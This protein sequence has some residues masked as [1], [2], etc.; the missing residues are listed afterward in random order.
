MNLLEWFNQ[1]DA[2][3]IEEF[4]RQGQEEHLY[5]DFKTVSNANLNSA[6]DKKNLAKALSGFANP[7]GGLIVWGVDARKNA[8]GIDCATGLN[9]I[10]PIQLFVSRLNTLTGE[11]VSPLVDGIIHKSII[12]GGEKGCAVTLV[13]ESQSGPHMAKP[14]E[15]RYYKRSGYSFYRMEHFDLEDM[16][17]RRQKPMLAIQMANHRRCPEEDLNEELDFYLINTG[18]AIAKYTGVIAT[19]DASVSIVN[20]T[21]QLRNISTLNND[22]QTLQYS[23]NLS[24]VRQNGNR[25]HIG[26]VKFRRVHQETAF[27]LHL[28]VYCE[29]MKAQ[30]NQ[31]SCVPL[32]MPNPIV[33]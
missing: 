26:S 31:Y 17:G 7:S 23:S 15:D 22:R 1:L 10:S 11:S 29:N 24:V 4:I 16:F 20:F 21:G 27:D 6:D 25:L 33:L 32:S 28:L 13:S 12:I 19:F 3:A 2:E 9:E 30:S 14:G 8:R 5:L 18:R